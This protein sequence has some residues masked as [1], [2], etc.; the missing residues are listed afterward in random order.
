M[1]EKKKVGRPVTRTHVPVKAAARQ[2]KEGEEKYI[3]IATTDRI[4]RMKDVAY[5]DR[6]NIKDVYAEAIDDRIK[7]FEKKNGALKKRGKN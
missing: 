7:K 2:T 6:L 5:W 4:D 3:I 1:R